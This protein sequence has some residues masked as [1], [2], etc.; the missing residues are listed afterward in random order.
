MEAGILGQTWVG[1]FPLKSLWYLSNFLS[2]FWPTQNKLN[3]KNIKLW[4][5]WFQK[6]SG[7][8]IRNTTCTKTVWEGLRPWPFLAVFLLQRTESPRTRTWELEPLSHLYTSR[9]RPCF[10]PTSKDTCTRG[11]GLDGSIDGILDQ[12]TQSE[13]HRFIQWAQDIACW[14]PSSFEA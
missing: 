6:D 1:C 5:T 14:G 9:P 4:K 12:V 13:I 11:T 7:K 3:L 8:Q 2:C 10:P